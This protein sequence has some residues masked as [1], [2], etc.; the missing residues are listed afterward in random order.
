MSGCIVILNGAP[1]SGKSSIA[2][3]MQTTIPGVWINFGVDALMQM[4]PEALRPG[5]GLRPG[6]ERPD[7]EPHVKTLFGALFNAVGAMA[8]AGVNVVADLGIHDFYSQRLGILDEA[9][10]RLSGMPVLLVGVHCPIDVIMARRNADSH[11]GFYE[12]GDVAP[13]T[14]TRW[15]AVHE[16]GIYD[17][18]LDS[19]KL[20][21]EESAAGIATLLQAWPRPTALERLAHGANGQPG[22]SPGSNPKVKAVPDKLAAKAKGT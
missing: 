6:G 2:R 10:R 9:V 17:L 5:I 16:P 11:G 4:T 20:S 21:P 19:S 15:S 13:L 7:L 8:R 18:E 12:T 14:V 3:V 1:R 22:T